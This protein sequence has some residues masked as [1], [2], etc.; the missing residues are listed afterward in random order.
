MHV[1]QRIKAADWPAFEQ[2]LD[3]A[4]NS[5]EVREAADDAGGVF[6]VEQMRTEVLRSR[7]A[8]TSTAATEY[9]DYLR[10][11]AWAT[12][13][14]LQRRRHSP[15]R[16]GAGVRRAS[17]GMVPCL[18]VVATT[19]FFLL[20]YYLYD[21]RTRPNLTDEFLSMG[22]LATAVTV[23]LVVVGLR[24]AEDDC[25]APGRSTPGP[26]HL[27]VAQARENWQQALLERGILPYVLGRI[28]F[29]EPLPRTGTHGRPTPSGARRT[30]DRRSNSRRCFG[31]EG[32]GPGDP[33]R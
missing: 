19:V 25:S 9:R 20:G 22:L 7:T 28:Q 24:A 5:E 29:P 10:A 33:E 26:G 30:G 14:G 1:S 27:S 6:P 15:R 3:Q 16:I 23:G 21:L 32:R 2:V 4:L 17:T 8:I 12:E 18:T 31:R 13:N 11:R